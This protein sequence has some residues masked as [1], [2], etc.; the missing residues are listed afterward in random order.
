MRGGLLGNRSV[1]PV[2]GLAEELLAEKQQ[3][4]DESESAACNKVKQRTKITFSEEKKVKSDVQQPETNNGCSD[5]VQDDDSLTK[6]SQQRKEKESEGIAI[7]SFLIYTLISIICILE[8][9][10]LIC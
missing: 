5:A 10:T 8:Y 2:K 7:H 1:A 4:L 3:D 9:K 6:N